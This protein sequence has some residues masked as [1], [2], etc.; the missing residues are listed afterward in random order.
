MDNS[1]RHCSSPLLARTETPPSLRFASFALILTTL[2]ACGS[3]SPGSASHE[4]PGDAAG[5]LAAAES[6]EGTP[7][8]VL[9]RPSDEGFLRA[10]LQGAIDAELDWSNGVPQCLGAERP[11]GDGVRLLFKGPAAAGSSLLI[12]IGA[13]PLEPGESRRNVP[14]NLTVIREGQGEFFAT[15]G[16]DKC[17]LDEV[18]QQRLDGTP[19]RY[20]LTA[21][22]YCTQPARSLNGTDSVLVPRFDVAAIVEFEAVA[23]TTTLAQDAT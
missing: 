4:A 19:R 6:T 17:A 15:Q 2:V 8:Q 10:R 14:A 21:R 20:R 7:Q 9:C 12:L 16:D 1:R 18:A 13:G 11:D 5:V 22:G 3:S 23:P